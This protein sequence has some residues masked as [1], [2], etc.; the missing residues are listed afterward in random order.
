[1]RAVQPPPADERIQDLER[2]LEGAKAEAADHARRADAT[3]AVR[4]ELETKVAQFGS[5]A[6]EQEPTAAALAEQLR[7]TEAIRADLER[8]ASEAESGGDAV[9]SDVA[10][11]T[12]ERDALRARLDE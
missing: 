11:L 3:E 9:R 1:K 8:R 2:A 12:A 6:Q 10:Q 7:E 5:R 4:A